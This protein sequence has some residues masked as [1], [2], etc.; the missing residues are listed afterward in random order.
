MDAEPRGQTLA[1]DAV[2]DEQTRESRKSGKRV[3]R[4]HAPADI[5]PAAAVEPAA[6]SSTF[7]VPRPV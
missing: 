4:D 6:N 7:D 2:E 3:S 1:D 5:E